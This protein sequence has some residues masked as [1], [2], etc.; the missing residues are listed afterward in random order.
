MTHPS[1]IVAIFT[2]NN[3]VPNKLPYILFHWM[4][5]GPLQDTLQIKTSCT[6]LDLLQINI[7]F[8]YTLVILTQDPPG[9]ANV[10]Y[11]DFVADLMKRSTLGHCE[12]N[13]FCNLPLMH[14][15]HTP[16]YLTW[17]LFSSLWIRLHCTTRTITPIQMPSRASLH[18]SDWRYSAL[19]MQLFPMNF[20]SRFLKSTLLGTEDVPQAK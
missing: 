8:R 18:D 12:S 14:A 11:I 20:L 9:R 6:H 1:S 19:T 3:F 17:H 10:S 2:I 16:R 5:Q 4:H 13:R 7:S 15:S